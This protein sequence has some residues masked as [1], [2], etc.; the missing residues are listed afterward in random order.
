M[1]QRTPVLP[2]KTLRTASIII[3]AFAVALV[4]F[5][6]TMFQ[7]GSKPVTTARDLQSSGLPGTVVDAR[8]QVGRIES[9]SLSA[10]PV[11]LTFIGSEGQE[12]VIETN[13]F[14]RFNPN[15]NSKRGWIDEFPTKDQIIAQPVTYRLGEHP[16]VELTSNLQTLA[17]A[18]W[19]F[20]NYLGLALM[21]LGGGAAIGGVISL[22]RA[23]RR[24]KATDD[25]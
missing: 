20:P 15:I 5:G 7:T 12:H 13:H 3:L 19:S 1:R 11:E 14:P 10:G 6:Q 22:R 16:A 24:I 21:V 17:T 4:L 2:A 25:R 18:G 23:L 9:G 8:V